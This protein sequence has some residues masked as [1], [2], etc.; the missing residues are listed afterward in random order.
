MYIDKNG[1]RWYRGNLHTHTTVSDGVLS[2][3][4]VKKLYRNM[5]YDFIALTDH[6]KYGEGTECDPSGLLVLSGCE[7][8]FGSIF[9][10]ESGIFHIISLLT[11]R[12]PEIY[13]SDSPQAAL[14]K[15]AA[16]G[17]ISILA[18]P[19]WSLNT[20]DLY[21][22][23]RGYWGTEIYNSVSG[24]PFNCRPYSGNVIDQGAVRGFYPALVADDDAHFY[25]GEEGMSYIMVRLGD[26]PLCTENLRTAL[27]SGDFIATQGPFFSFGIE[28]D[29]AVL[30]SETPLSC[31]TF[32]TN[33]AFAWDTCTVAKSEPIFEARF[34]I[35]KG[36]TFVRAECTSP[37]GEVG[38]SRIIPLKH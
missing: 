27:L 5:G 24:T 6:W 16:A 15:I 17:G 37:S 22:S 14:D 18:H 35:E 30:R 26:K 34:K 13:E 38:Y 23:L 25:R 29:E 33:A 32:F 8:N 28:G 12:N 36:Y 20:P 2:P 7:Y 31:V 11:E 3:E 4:A 9:D 21:L 1:D 19:A 10:A